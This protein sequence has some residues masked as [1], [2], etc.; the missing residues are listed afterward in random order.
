ME[1]VGVR[2]MNNLAFFKEKKYFSPDI[3]DS[4]DPG[5]PGS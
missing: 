2:D 1:S 5:F 3:P 4:R